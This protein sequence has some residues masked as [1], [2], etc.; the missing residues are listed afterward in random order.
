MDELVEDEELLDDE[1]E[2]LLDVEVP[3]PKLDEEVEELV[4]TL[5]LEDDEVEV[6]TLP[7]D[8]DVEDT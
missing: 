5:P 2:V 4:D 1:V 8:E 3:P 7:L 6:D